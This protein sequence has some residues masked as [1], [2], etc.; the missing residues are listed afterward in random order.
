MLLLTTDGGPDWSVMS[1][2]VLLYPQRVFR[3]LDLDFLCLSNYTPG[4]SAF[5]PVEHTWSPKLSDVTFGAVLE[6]ESVP[7]C[8]QNSISEK[9]RDAN[10]KKLFTWV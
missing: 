7:P 3:C 1:W 5:N 10:E 4:Q 6:G 8:S 9:V 2:T